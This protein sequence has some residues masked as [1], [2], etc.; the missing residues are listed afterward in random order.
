[1]C[2]INVSYIIYILR[3]TTNKFPIDYIPTIFENYSASITIDGKKI[4]LGL[5]D[6]A[7]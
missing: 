6:T 3:Y 5:W 4:N 1:M 2:I 7:G